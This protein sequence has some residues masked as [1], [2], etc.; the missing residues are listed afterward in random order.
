LKK[1]LSKYNVP[2]KGNEDFSSNLE[3]NLSNSTTN[4]KKITINPL[5]STINT[6]T[7]PPNHDM[8]LFQFLQ[9]NMKLEKILESLSFLVQ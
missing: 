9:I 2:F 4:S 7:F 6:K 1:I 3:N 5:E 8:I